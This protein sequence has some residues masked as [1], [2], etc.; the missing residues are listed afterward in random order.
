M[1]TPEKIAT[2]EP[3]NPTLREMLSDALRYW[4]PRRLIYNGALLLV[5]AGCFAA[6]WPESKLMLQTDIVLGIFVLA[7]LANV[8]YCA[9]YLPDIAIQHSGMRDSWLRW[10]W[11]VLLVGTLFA[12]AI[13]YLFV[14]GM[15]GL[16]N[17]MG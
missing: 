12:A 11:V 16:G 9:A 7:V 2:T 1:T 15:F 3:E 17:G 13:T 4:E 6:A 14:A 5:V 10:R 8:A